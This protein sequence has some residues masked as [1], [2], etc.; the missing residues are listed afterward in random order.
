MSEGCKPG[1]ESRLA[2][3]SEPDRKRQPDRHLG[4]YQGRSLSA[5]LGGARNGTGQDGALTS[6][7]KSILPGSSDGVERAW[8]HLL[9][10]A[11]QLAHLP[12]HADNEARRLIESLT[13]CA[14]GYCHV[15]IET[16]FGTL[17]AVCGRLRAVKIGHG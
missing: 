8:Q 6:L 14:L 17:Y 12:A 11:G 16:D 7:Q 13:D 1:L 9:D 2:K 3:Q 4:G 5:L 15:S 10:A